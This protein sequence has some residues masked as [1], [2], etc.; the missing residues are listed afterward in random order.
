M[1]IGSKYHM[2]QS[3]SKQKTKKMNH[4]EVRREYSQKISLLEHFALVP[5]VPV[6]NI[7]T[8]PSHPDLARAK[9]IP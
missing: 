1:G 9:S 4:T 3:K 6:L 7:R 8:R 2:E 5:P